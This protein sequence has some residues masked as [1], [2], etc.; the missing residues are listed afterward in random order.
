MIKNIIEMIESGENNS[1]II[2]ALKDYNMFI[3]RNAI[4]K[5]SFFELKAVTAVFTDGLTEKTYRANKV[6][7]EI[8]V[9]R[10]ILVTAMD[11]LQTA[12]IIDHKS[13]GCLGCAYTVLNEN[14]FQVLQ[15]VA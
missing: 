8:E 13:M 9:T 11:K 14:I 1:A 10:S 4:S 7:K 12:G 6:A 3:V 2:Q 15:E 5:L